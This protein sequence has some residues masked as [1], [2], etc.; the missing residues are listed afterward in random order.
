MSWQCLNERHSALVGHIYDAYFKL[1]YRFLFLLAVVNPRDECQCRMWVIPV[2]YSASFKV[3]LDLKRLIRF[4]AEGVGTFLSVCSLVFCINFIANCEGWTFNLESSRST[5]TCFGFIPNE[6]SPHLVILVVMELWG[7]SQTLTASGSRGLRLLL[8][9]VCSCP[10]LFSSALSPA[11]LF[12]Y[13]LLFFPAKYSL[14]ASFFFLFLW[15]QTF[16]WD[17][18]CEIAFVFQDLSAISSWLCST[19]L[20]CF[21]AAHHR[22]SLWNRSLSGS[23]PTHWETAGD[24]LLS[25]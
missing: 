3:I 9:P 17:T 10:L 13:F 25:H 14:F 24:P 23:P 12:S 6:N 5:W 19:E 7:S 21:T 1:F 16:V 4:T 11:P 20:R 22:L 2:I 8:I 18:G 15:G